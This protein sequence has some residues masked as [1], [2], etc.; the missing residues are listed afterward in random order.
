MSEGLQ[1]ADRT[2]R[3]NRRTTASPLALLEKKLGLV[4]EF[5]Q[6]TEALAT[7][8]AEDTP[9]RVEEGLSVRQSLMR[10]IDRTDQTLREEGWEDRRHWESLP[11]PVRLRCRFLADRIAETFRRI[12]DVDRACE[13]ALRAGRDSLARELSAL[14]GTQTGL[15]RY[16]GSREGANRFLSVRT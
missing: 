9:R 1:A 7:A 8:L 12:A 11:E 13:A 5:L 4:E 15:R 2:Q 3:L 6:A 16:G 14:N 10:K